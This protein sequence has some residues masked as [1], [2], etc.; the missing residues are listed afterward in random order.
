MR[1][2]LLVWSID[3]L[4][5]PSSCSITALRSWRSF[6][7]SM[8]YWLNSSGLP[9][10]TWRMRVTIETEPV[11]RPPG[12][13][14]TPGLKVPSGF[15]FPAFLWVRHCQMVPHRICSRE[16]WR[17][18]PME[19]DDSQF[20]DELN[21][22]ATELVRENRYKPANT[23]A[24]KGFLDLYVLFEFDKASEYDTKSLLEVMG[25]SL[26]EQDL[27][28]H[29][30]VMESLPKDR[31][32]YTVFPADA[33]E[34]G[35]EFLRKTVKNIRETMCPKS[36]RTP[37][38][39]RL[40]TKDLMTSLVTSVF[41]GIGVHDSALLGACVLVTLVVARATHKSFCEMTDD[42]VI[43]AVEQELKKGNRRDRS[44]GKLPKSE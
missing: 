25:L 23:D 18:D 32:H 26:D 13:P 10:N 37:T 34:K 19:M 28:L 8:T 17:R 4:G 11:G 14:E 15:L 30:R 2:P 27:A 5:L 16:L 43:E 38:G 20:I 36:R 35:L 1:S 12:L 6:K 31:Y 40:T 41:T 33:A 3:C 24:D 9:S 44:S 29:H 22:L 42:A 21:K 7:M 39:V